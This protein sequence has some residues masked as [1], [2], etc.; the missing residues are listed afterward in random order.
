MPFMRK[1][2]FIILPVVVVFVFLVID[3]L[4]FSAEH[5]YQSRGRPQLYSLKKNQK[6][7]LS[8]ALS[9]TE[10]DQ[11]KSKNK[12]AK[13][14]S[15]GARKSLS[16]ARLFV[17]GGEEK[18]HGLIQTSSSVEIAD[19]NIDSKSVSLSLP[20]QKTPTSSASFIA[21]APP[22]VF[23]SL[24]FINEQVMEHG[25]RFRNIPIGG[26]SALS[27]DPVRDVF[28]ALSDDK[29]QRGPPRFYKFKLNKVEKGKNYELRVI[30]QVFLSNRK[31]R[32]LMPIDPEGVAFFKPDQMFISSE[33]AQLPDLNVPP[34]VFVFNSKGKRL[35][36]W[37][38]PRM[39]WPDNLDQL[40][41]WGVK[42]NKAFEAL[43]IDPEQ[44][45]LWL[46]TESS[47]HQDEQRGE[48]HRGRQYIRISRFDIKTAHMNG[49]FV[50]QMASNIK[51]NNLRGK[52]GLTDFLSLGGKK[53]LV[54][55]RAY[56]KDKSI[57]GNRKT[58]ANLVRLFL[59][60]CSV[61]SDVSEYEELKEGRFVTCGK[62]LLAD[63][64]SLMGGEVDNIEGITM[65]PS[66]S[67]GSYLLVLVSDNNFSRT[68]KTQF[69]FFHYSPDEKNR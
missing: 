51:V 19:S 53:L 12:I 25:F 44:N 7:K 61:A 41:E 50:Y 5:S 59:T 23:F 38:L 64:S 40:G 60:D 35:S 33:G 47:L 2:F 24:K 4:V 16:D 67:R 56:L 32:Q 21:G 27:Y 63:V 62:N 30:D 31:G 69:L 45:Q 1:W 58:D 14:G 34:A 6:E 43:S 49:Q 8:G 3:Y 20:A 15:I 39:Y 9:I 17:S 54:V 13:E 29:G 26:L 37:P 66:V 28:I 22:V 11:N 36:S 65:G 10:K 48:S 46:A 52:N 42:E 57:S 68:Q 18:K 55:E